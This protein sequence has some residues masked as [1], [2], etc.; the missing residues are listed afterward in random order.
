MFKIYVILCEECSRIVNAT[1]TGS[2]IYPV[3]ELLKTQSQVVYAHRRGN[4]SGLHIEIMFSLLL[5][6]FLPEFD[7]L[8]VGSLNIR[9]TS[10]FYVHVTL[11]TPCTFSS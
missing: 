6:L 10:P 1:V 7:Q 4:S 3:P 8:F 9:G 5:G 11:L 2:Q